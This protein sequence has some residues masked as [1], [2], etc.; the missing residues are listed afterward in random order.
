MKKIVLRRWQKPKSIG[1]TFEEA[2]ISLVCE[3]NNNDNDNDN[4]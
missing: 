4:N 1:D 3:N 2:S